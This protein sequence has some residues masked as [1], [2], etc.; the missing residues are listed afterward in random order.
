MKV[1]WEVE[2]GQ[3]REKRVLCRHFTPTSKSLGPCTT[4][5]EQVTCLRCLY[6]MNDW[7]HWSDARFHAGM[8]ARAKLQELK[9]AAG[10]DKATGLLARIA[11]R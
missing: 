7:V 5:P 1:H 10:G 4:V 8:T 9:A 2:Y 11:T 6:I 3:T